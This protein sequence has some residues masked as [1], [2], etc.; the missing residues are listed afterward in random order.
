MSDDLDH[1]IKFS[2]IDSGNYAGLPSTIRYMYNPVDTVQYSVLLVLN[3]MITS[4]DLTGLLPSGQDD[5][6]LLPDLPRCGYEVKK[7]NKHRN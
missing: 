2:L 3:D 5:V 4:L 7:T 6:G 1:E